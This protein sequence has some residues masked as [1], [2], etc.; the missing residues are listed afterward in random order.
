MIYKMLK[1]EP[2]NNPAFLGKTG[3]LRSARAKKDIVFYFA[4]A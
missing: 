2:M 3:L 1:H 4:N